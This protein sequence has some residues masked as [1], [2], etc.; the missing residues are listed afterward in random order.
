[1]NRHFDVVSQEVKGGHEIKNIGQP[2]RVHIEK[3]KIDDRLQFSEQEMYDE[4]R[5]RHKYN[6]SER[7]DL[8]RM[9]KKIY[10]Q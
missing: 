1:M 5:A 9:A 4:F 6:R 7:K 2:R 8:I 10:V 3:N